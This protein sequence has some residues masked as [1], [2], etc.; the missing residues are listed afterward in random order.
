MSECSVTL[1]A[2]AGVSISLGGVRI[3][4]DALHNQQLPGFSTLSLAQW[5]PLLRS[6]AL[7]PPDFI[8]FTHCHS[9][10]YS[11]PLAAKAARLWPS[12]RLVLPEQAFAEQHLLCG[13]ESVLSA[14]EVSLRF[15]RLPHEGALYAS[16]PHYGILLSCNGFQILLPGDGKIADGG[17]KAYLQN[18]TVDL[19][20]LDF[21]WV[22]LRKGREF[23][24]STIC[25]RHLLVY[26][27]PFVQDD[28]FGYRAA[29][30]RSR[31]L[32]DIP[33]V[34]LLMDPFQT[35]TI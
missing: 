24:R 9:D 11:F 28:R 5:E 23:I 14:G 18:T 2:N 7:T 29:A 12:A 4:V 22:T 3:W 1:I 21:P 25:P 19:A 13:Q 34:R 30:E 17:L 16:V 27:L 26:H 33:D 31:T 10:H 8:C 20:L 32:L 6:D 35:E 15:F